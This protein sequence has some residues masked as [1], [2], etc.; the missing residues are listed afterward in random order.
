MLSTSALGL[1]DRFSNLPLDHDHYD[2][3]ICNSLSNL[4]HFSDMQHLNNLYDVPDS[5]G[6]REQ[7]GA[8]QTNHDYATITHYQNVTN[9]N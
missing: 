9:A 2:Y 5:S 6:I 8:I 7:E 1:K 3:M 4:F